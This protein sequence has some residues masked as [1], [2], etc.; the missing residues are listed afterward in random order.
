MKEKVKT[1]TVKTN[2]W[3]GLHGEFYIPLS[4]LINPLTKMPIL[5]EEQYRNDENEN[6]VEK[7]LLLNGEIVKLMEL[8]L[9]RY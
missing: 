9:D 5:Y 3:N 4:S 6:L 8:K 2:A 7:H 1:I